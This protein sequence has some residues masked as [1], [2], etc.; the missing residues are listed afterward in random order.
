[1]QTYQLKKAFTDKE[2]EKLE[3]TFVKENSFDVLI[4]DDADGF[5]LDGRPL[6]RYRRN[7][8]TEEKL[9]TAYENVKGAIVFT[10]GRG[11]A[12]GSSHLRVRKDGT[13]GKMVVGN[14]VWG[15]VVGWMDRNG[16]SPY[17]RLTSYSRDHFEDFKKSWDF[18]KEVDDW[19]KKLMPD[20][21][22]LQREIADATNPNY[23]IKDTCFTTVTANKNFQTA[24]HKDAGDYAMGFGNLTVI[25]NGM[26][27]GGYFCLPQF[28]AAINMRT[29]DLLMVDVHQWHGNTPI[30]PKE[31]GKELRISFVIYYRENM[32][33][34]LSPEK[35]LRL[36]KMKNGGG[37]NF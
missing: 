2:A 21:Y 20:H 7:V 22:K 28:R 16:K 30:V 4:E 29:C 10:D 33:N 31:A 12:S 34:C 18:V 11:V 9:M 15:G 3:R 19:Y 17:C 32:F 27:D 5:T 13:V 14:K 25:N 1:M 8:L 6:F 26:Y 37:I 35:E 23:V 36:V 24:V